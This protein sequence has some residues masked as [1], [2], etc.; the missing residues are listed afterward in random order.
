MNYNKRLFSL[1]SIL[2]LSS[3]TLKPA[4]ESYALFQKDGQ[5]V[6]VLGDIHALGL[7]PESSLA[8][9]DTVDS[10]IIYP[11]TKMLSTSVN[12]STFILE[13]S[14]DY[15]SRTEALFSTGQFI[16]IFHALP[17][18]AR[19]NNYSL[20]SVSFNLGDN[21]PTIVQNLIEMF[22]LLNEPMFKDPDVFFSGKERL[23]DFF[24]DHATVQNIFD[25]IKKLITRLKIDINNERF[26][27]IAS[28]LNGLLKTIQSYKKHGKASFTS[29]ELR[30]SYIDVF[31]SRYI[32]TRNI[33]SLFAPLYAW[34]LPL[35]D[36]LTDANFIIE[37]AKALENNNLVILFVGNNHAIA[38]HKFL[39]ESNFEPI[40]I[41]GL[42]TKSSG[43]V[44]FQGSRFDR[45]ELKVIL[46]NIVNEHSIDKS[47]TTIKHCAVCNK[48][49]S[50]K[51]CSRCKQ[52][53]YCS[54]EC[55]K[56]HWS[57]HKSECNKN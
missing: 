44:E 55:Q 57:S 15:L 39:I 54:V 38:L 26:S 53:C 27:T 1:L 31:A 23:K 21:C 5:K 25:E 16:D 7:N 10:A 22:K 49:D 20:G 36:N 2:L 18:F 8:K 32:N 4:L 42:T 52:T 12:P 35:V 56:K 14:E 17:N 46:S 6:L 37:T 41:Q 30:T 48:P 3:F 45:D 34:I 11:F 33:N 9:L 28:T 29:N 13:S 43:P 40:T 47:S 50:A 24:K 51:R 19:S